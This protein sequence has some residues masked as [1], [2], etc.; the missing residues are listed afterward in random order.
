MIDLEKVMRRFIME[1]RING[2]VKK[3]S[4]DYQEFRSD[5]K[6]E[7]DDTI[8]DFREYFLNKFSLDILEGMSAED[9]LQELMNLKN[10]ESLVYHLE[11]KNDEEFRTDY[12]GGILGGSS[13]KYTIFFSNKFDQ[14]VK[15]E[16]NSQVPITDEEASKR[17]EQIRKNLIKLHYFIQN[18]SYETVDDIRL[19]INAIENDEDVNHFYRYGWVHKYFHIYYPE[20]ISC[21]H[22]QSIFTSLLVKLN[23]PFA[24]VL[25][26]DEMIP[27]FFDYFYIDLSNRLDILQINLSRLIHKAYPGIDA[28]TYFKVEVSKYKPDELEEMIHSEFFFAP[29][30]LNYDL[31]DITSRNEMSHFFQSID[32]NEYN[33]T[34]VN[35]LTKGITEKDIV[36]LVDEN[37]ARYVGVAE[38]EYEYMSNE[39][40]RHR[41]PITWHKIKPENQF[42]VSGKV[43]KIINRVNKATDQVNIEIAIENGKQLTN[44]KSEAVIRP[45]KGKMRIISSLLGK[46][47]QVILTGAP[48]TGKTFWAQKTVY[49]LIARQIYKT[50]Y[51]NLSE[52]Q[53]EK[54]KSSNQ[55]KIIVLHSN[56]GYEE[57][58]EGLRPES[59]NNELVFKV[60]A[61]VFKEF[62]I[63]ALNDSDN[64]YYLILDEINRADLTKIFGELIYSIENSKRGEYINLS[65][66]D[67][68]FTVPKNLYIIGTMNNADKSVS[69]IDLALRRRFGF[70]ELEPDYDL[71]DRTILD[72][73][74]ISDKIE[75]EDDD[76]NE[77]NDIEVVAAIHIGEWLENLNKRLIQTLGSEGK[78]LLI[79]HSYFLSKDEVITEAGQFID[80]LKY[81]IIPLLNEYTYNNPYQLK[82]IIGEKM[83]DSSNRLRTELLREDDFGT[84][85]EALL[86]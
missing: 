54:V 82:E 59:V 67:E 61:G 25:S 66:S 4:K 70:I 81:E 27:Y 86:E 52:S 38:G 75:T 77:I 68:E 19:M 43:T 49:E 36:L 74:K 3:L 84:L 78:D 44:S 40:F 9:S 53:K 26:N 65:V 63:K 35:L 23:H 42:T 30:N 55:L 22:G 37:M 12:F 34:Q 85:V 45:L 21:Y 17:A 51:V 56:Y 2:I 39:K 62:A 14:W 24:E 80:I 47:K 16:G 58:V 8:E 18:N 83:F 1:T 11:F 73:S 10:R 28:T 5:I 71:L 79:G 41:I 33:A 15:W 76:E 6:F 57:F 60:K 13:G 29:I 69:L 32:Y 50:S 64:N 31:S 48:G 7:D 72:S 20:K 46:K